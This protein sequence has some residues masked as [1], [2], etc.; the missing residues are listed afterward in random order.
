M[1]Q[2]KDIWGPGIWRQKSGVSPDLHPAKPWHNLVPAVGDADAEQTMWGLS[3]GYAF[4]V[5]ESMA[6][7]PVWR[8]AA[9]EAWQAGALGEGFHELAKSRFAELLPEIDDFTEMLQS[10]AAAVLPF[11][12]GVVLADTLLSLVDND[13][14]E[15]E[16]Y[17]GLTPQNKTPEAT[18][19]P[20]KKLLGNWA[21]AW[22]APCEEHDTAGPRLVRQLVALS[23]TDFDEASPDFVAQLF[24]VHLAAFLRSLLPDEEHLL[25]ARLGQ[26][27]AHLTAQIKAA[28]A[29]GFY[30]AFGEETCCDPL[31][32]KAKGLLAQ[33]AKEGVLMPRVPLFT[34]GEVLS[35]L[36]CQAYIDAYK[37]A[38]LR[39]TLEEVFASSTFQNLPTQ[40]S[41]LHVP[42][43]NRAAVLRKLVLSAPIH[44]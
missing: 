39:Q 13:D 34:N 44:F 31:G 5:A 7:V 32:L 18:F 17:L 6:D 22:C 19:V 40:Q 29:H 21:E 26:Q 14:P 11:G 43:L 28:T 23:A 27:E 37:D 2:A 15:L 12:G 20:L 3:V 25:D 16:R 9:Y 36:Q 10:L 35:A 4:T 30:N 42:E 33:V 24:Y 41:S 8:I 1:P 38:G